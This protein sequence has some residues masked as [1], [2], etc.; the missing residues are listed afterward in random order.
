MADDADGKGAEPGRAKRLSP[1]AGCLLSLGMLALLA[2]VG[3]ALLRFT[4]ERLR[5]VEAGLNRTDRRWGELIQSGYFES[6]DDLERRYAPRAGAVAQVDDWTFRAN[7]LRARGAEIP[8]VKPA[9]ER[10]L[11]VLG[12]SFC[13]GMWSSEEETVAGHLE[14]RLNAVEEELS[15]GLRWRTVNLG[16]PGYHLGQQLRA[17]EEEGLA[18]EPDLVLVYF[19]TNDIVEEGF[20]YDDDLRIVRVDPMPLPASW[21]RA[22]WRSHLYGQAARGLERVLT[23]GRRPHLEA[24]NPWGHTR[25]SNQAYTADVLA[26]MAALCRE[27]DLPLFAIHQPLMTW[28]DD[29]RNP[30]WDILPLVEWMEERFE[31]HGVPRL[32]LLGWMRGYTDGIDRGPEGVG[33]PAEFRLEQFFAD[34]EVQAFF[35]GEIDLTDPNLKLPQDPD[36]HLT[37]AGYGE[38]ARLTHERMRAEGLLP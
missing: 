9:N 24:R 14:R 25:P 29:A 7:R 2:L 19:N 6:V 4:G 17:L 15:S 38:L 20:F 36:F 32:N 31:E 33:P 35:R 5:Q 1:R 26:R 3:E 27:R 11:V 22:L 23:R 13:F 28:M 30:D 12:D 21:R 8:E 18:A 10:R 16:V 37:G 34:E